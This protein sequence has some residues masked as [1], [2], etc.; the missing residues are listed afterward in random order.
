MF[1]AGLKEVMK[2]KAEYLKQWGAKQLE[3]DYQRVC[4]SRNG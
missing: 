1:C 3:E 2:L 4:K